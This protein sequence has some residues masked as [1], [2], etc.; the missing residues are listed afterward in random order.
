LPNLNELNKER[1][2]DLTKYYASD[3]P[4][5]ISFKQEARLWKCQWEPVANKPATLVATLSEMN[6]KLF[7]NIAT[8]FRILLVQPVMAAGVERANSAFKNEPQK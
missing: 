8:I 6:P 3:L 1:L 7:P 2:D 5:E 4:S